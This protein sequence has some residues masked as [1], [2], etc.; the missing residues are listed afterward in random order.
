MRDVPWRRQAFTLIELLVVIAIIA[1]LI[2]LLLPAVQ[3]VREAA[4][5]IRCSNNLKQLGIALHNYHGDRERLPPGGRVRNMRQDWN[6]TQDQGSWLVH[7][8]PYVEQDNLYR[9]YE[10]VLKEDGPQPPRYSVLDY[11][12][13]EQAGHILPRDAAGNYIGDQRPPPKVYICPSADYDPIQRAGSTY[14]GSL[15]P[16]CAMG[17]CGYNPYQVWCDMPAVGIPRSPEHGNTLDTADLRGVFNRLGAKVRF[18]DITD[19]TANTIMVGEILPHWHDHPWQWVHFNGGASHATTLVPINY[20]TDRQVSC[21]TDPPRSWQNW[22]LSWGF[23]S[24]HAQGANFL[25]CDGSVQFISQN[26]DHQLYQWL[27]CRNDGFPAQ[28]P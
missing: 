27:G 3:K 6:W 15:G 18:A 14:S 11:G 16:Q 21:A 2:G 13:G 22:N 23:K 17:P 8:L 5:R 19:G 24:R 9:I 26:I 12:H 25:M 4:N 28:L 20:P 10:P 7:I 1:I